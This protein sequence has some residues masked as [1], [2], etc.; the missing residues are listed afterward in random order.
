MTLNRSV[1][2]TVYIVKDG[3][4]LLH[5]HKKYK[6][7]FPVGGH[8]LP[9]EFPHEAALREVREETGLSVK[10]LRTENA[11]DFDSARV[12]RVPLPYL[13]YYEGIGHE[14]EF[15]DFIF[16]AVTDEENPHPMKGESDTFRWFTV[17]ELQS[18]ETLKP[19][20]RNTAI[21]VLE[22]VHRF[23]ENI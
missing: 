18:D 22:N 16:I 20:I 21:H 12:R 6:T 23:K 1:T 13:T 3:K 15:Y 7:W 10:L 9:N 19:H 4:V 14:E 2:A 5:M 11:E 17:E 8:L